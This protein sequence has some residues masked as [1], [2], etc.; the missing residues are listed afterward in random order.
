MSPLTAAII[1]AMVSGSTFYLLAWRVHGR[2]QPPTVDEIAAYMER[3]VA[4]EQM[5]LQ[6]H[7]LRTIALRANR[8]AMPHPNSGPPARVTRIIMAPK[9]GRETIFREK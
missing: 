7:R 2:S 8:I 9:E 3:K 6:E 5:E 1:S 4:M